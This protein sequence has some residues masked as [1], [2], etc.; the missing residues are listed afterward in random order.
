M[1][2]I[3]KPQSADD[4]HAADGSV[5]ADLSDESRHNLVGYFD[6]LIQMDLEQKT[7]NKGKS[8]DETSL[9]TNTNCNSKDD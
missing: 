8:D 9:H 4:T 1:T 3:Y 5:P 6:I 7:L 2:E